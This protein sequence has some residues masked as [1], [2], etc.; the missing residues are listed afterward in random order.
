MPNRWRW[1]YETDRLT[2]KD[3]QVLCPDLKPLL[4]IGT[5]KKDGRQTYQ[6]IGCATCA[7]YQRCYPS[8]EGEP[9]KF[10]LKAT[11]HQRWR[12]N[13]QHNQTQEY[14]EAQ[15]ARFVSEG[16]FG[17]AKSNHRA[18]R[19]PYRSDDMNLIAAAG[20]AAMMNWRI[21]ANNKSS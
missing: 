21:L 6:G 17:L 3:G 12:E 7:L 2:W 8:G 4:P 14:K 11:A 20:V 1:R 10:T 13:R 19:A 18:D 5:L 15:R 16:R 9:K